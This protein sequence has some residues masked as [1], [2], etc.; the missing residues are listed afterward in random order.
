MGIPILYV[1]RS[2]YVNHA[3][4]SENIYGPTPLDYKALA[5]TELC[6]VG[7]TRFDTIHGKVC[8]IDVP[9]Q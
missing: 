4:I 5:N 8:G 6:A 7:G 3:Y 9:K 1:W 2:G